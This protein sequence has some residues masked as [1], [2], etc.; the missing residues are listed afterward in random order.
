MIQAPINNQTST[1]FAYSTSFQI[2]ISD[3]IV[4]TP[5]FY[6][7]TIGETTYYSLQFPFILYKLESQQTG[8]TKIFTRGASFYPVISTGIN[9]F[10]RQITLSWKYSTNPSSTESLSTGDILVGNAEYPL[11]FYDLTVYETDSGLE[12]NPDNAKSVL[13]NGIVNMYGQT[14]TGVSNFEEVKYTEYTTNDS[15]NENVYLT[16]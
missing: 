6:V 7:V 14:A 16:N 2:N 5:V 13:Y 8:K 10:D 4:Q 9:K 1:A 15:D 12:L 3:K 11:G